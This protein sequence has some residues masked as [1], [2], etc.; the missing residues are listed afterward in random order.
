MYLMKNKRQ[1]EMTATPKKYPQGFFKD[2]PCRKCGNMFT[3]K[4]PSHLHCSQECADEAIMDAYLNRCYGIIYKDYTAMLESQ[5]SKC[6][7]C[8]GE[9]FCMAKHHKLKL[10]VDHCHDTGEVRGL[11]C[12]NCNR[13][14]GLF[15]DDE[16]VLRKAIDYLT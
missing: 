4:A 11:L 8:G 1:S 2:K 7:I 16:E 14:L 15:K 10:V 6:A 13:G 5:D 9:G 3:P 12:H